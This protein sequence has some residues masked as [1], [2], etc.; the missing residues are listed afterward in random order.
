MKVY[1]LLETTSGER[2]SENVEFFEL[3]F[4]HNFDTLR[5][6]PS[7]DISL[8]PV[9]T[10]TVIVSIRSEFTDEEIFS[11]PPRNLVSGETLDIKVAQ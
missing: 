10:G 3:S 6:R 4:Q 2:A 1:A 5:A 7:R 8:R 9:K 11:W